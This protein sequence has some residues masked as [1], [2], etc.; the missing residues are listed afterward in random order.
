MY[1][2]KNLNLFKSFYCR[3]EKC[4]SSNHFRGRANYHILIKDDQGTCIK[5]INRVNVD[6]NYNFDNNIPLNFCF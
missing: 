1:L 6:C 2:V 4:F 5:K 3:F